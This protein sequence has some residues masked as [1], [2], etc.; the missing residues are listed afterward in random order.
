MRFLS[1][2]IGL[3]V[4]D[5]SGE[6]IGTVADLIV[7]IGGA[8]PPVTGLVARTD[9]AGSSSRGVDVAVSTM[10]G[11]RLG[12]RTIDIGKFRQRPTEILLKPTCSTSRS[13]TSRGARSSASTTSASTTSRAACAS[14]RSTSE[15][16]ACCAA[17]ASRDRSG[18][19]PG[20]SGPRRP[21]A[22]HRLGG[23]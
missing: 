23:R 22:L 2:C 6:P 15:R 5:P 1:Q 21:G 4:R 17:S 3:P 14:S 20:T 18:P 11:A 10:T 7:A 9:G 19:S 12:V 8:Y 13:S 16:P